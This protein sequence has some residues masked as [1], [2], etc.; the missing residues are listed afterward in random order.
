M[1]TALLRDH[2][3]ILGARRGG[4]WGQESP[5]AILVNVT[6]IEPGGRSARGYQVGGGAVRFL[7]MGAAPGDQ[8]WLR[9]GD[10]LEPEPADLGD[11]LEALAS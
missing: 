4:T 5:D 8:A 7:Y 6:E 1:R 10:L 2:A 3:S 11:I 9:P